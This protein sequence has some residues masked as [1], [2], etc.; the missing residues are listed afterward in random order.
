M[1]RPARKR[2]PL[3]KPT[4]VDAYKIVADAWMHEPES[5]DSLDRKLRIVKFL[6]DQISK[7]R[8][9]RSKGAK[10]KRT[11]RVDAIFDRL[12][13]QNPNCSAEEVRKFK[14]PKPLREMSPA[15]FARHWQA[16]KIRAK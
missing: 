2:A 14:A 11:Q 3:W 12:F 5:T 9:G 10:G 7:H 15:T 1:K 16:A 13:A 8:P 6:A 4:K